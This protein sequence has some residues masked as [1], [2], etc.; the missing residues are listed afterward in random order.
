MNVHK[1][2]RV[3]AAQAVVLL[4]PIDNS[5]RLGCRIVEAALV[6]EV[7]ELAGRQTG[8]VLNVVKVGLERHDFLLGARRGSTTVGGELWSGR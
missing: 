1:G 6:C 7:D 3:P 8:L 2:H 4:E 5:P